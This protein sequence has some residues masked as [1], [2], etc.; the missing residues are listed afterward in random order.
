HLQS[1][2]NIF[3]K[4]TI[5]L[6]SYK[7]EMHKIGWHQLGTIVSLR[8]CLENE[9]S[10]SSSSPYSSPVLTAHQLQRHAGQMVMPCVHSDAKIT[11]QAVLLLL[12][13]LVLM[14][15]VTVILFLP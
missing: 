14:R 10:S 2:V 13:L 15:S 7:R 5:K 1:S 3:V 12:L 11:L 9:F 8:I 4:L 6:E